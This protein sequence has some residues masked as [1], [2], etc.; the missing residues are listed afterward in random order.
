MSS[1]QWLRWRD[2]TPGGDGSGSYAG[3]PRVGLA[4]LPTGGVG[5]RTRGAWRHV[6]I[7]TLGRDTFGRVAGMV[8]LVNALSSGY[9][10]LS[11]GAYF[12][13]GFGN[14]GRCPVLG[15]QSCRCQRRCPEGILWRSAKVRAGMSGNELRFAFIEVSRGHRRT[16]C[17]F[18]SLAWLNPT[19]RCPGRLPR[20]SCRCCRPARIP[21][22]TGTDR[23]FLRRP[24]DSSGWWPVRIHSRMPAGRIRSIR[25]ADRDLQV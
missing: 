3:S 25:L 8:A 24:V 7:S 19:S 22:A 10:T 2:C 21:E 15:W 11:N 17:P 6:G 4:N 1:W 13:Y 18:R 14:P 16:L 20:I 9:I 12:N 23:D 5:C